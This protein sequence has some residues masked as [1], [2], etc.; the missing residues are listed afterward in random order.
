M[1]RTTKRMK[2]YFQRILSEADAG[3]TVDQWVILQQLQEE[4][5][6]SQ[7]SL[8]KATFKD[9]PTV[10]R[11]IDLLTQKGL[12]ER[13][14]DA[15]D[16]RKFRICLTSTGRKKI[17][18]VLPLVIQFRESAW[19]GL[20]NEQIDNLVHSLNHIFENLNKNQA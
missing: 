3:I 20:S 9:A 18:A 8:A 17:E 6:R 1:E 12:V 4:D 11:I 5:G 15:N 13:E 16:R 14:L 10:T 7:L 2:Q 19:A